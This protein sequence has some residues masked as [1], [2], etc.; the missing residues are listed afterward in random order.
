GLLLRFALPGAPAGCAVT[1]ATLRLDPGPAGR[2]VALT[3][4]R[5]S[6]PWSATTLTE[7]PSVGPPVVSAPAPGPRT[8]SVTGLVAASYAGPDEGLLVRGAGTPAA[9]VRLTIT[10]G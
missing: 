6:A 1:A 9:P 4:R 2:A 7:P 10:F 8:W 3:V 5:V